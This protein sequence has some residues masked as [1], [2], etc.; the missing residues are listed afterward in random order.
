MFF[1]KKFIG[2]DKQWAGTV[3]GGKLVCKRRAE[4]EDRRAEN[5]IWDMNWEGICTY[6][7][8]VMGKQS[9]YF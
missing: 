7:R 3:E 1:K 2:T 5:S 8:G 6:N 4:S 9:S